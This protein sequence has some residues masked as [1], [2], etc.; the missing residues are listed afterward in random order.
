MF[1]SIRDDPDR[2]P[3]HT[4]ASGAGAHVK[5]VPGGGTGGSQ[6]QERDVS[7]Q[8]AKTRAGTARDA[9]LQPAHSG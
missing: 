7:D 8:T 1:L 9:T 2:E 6:C 5:R 3:S 4:M